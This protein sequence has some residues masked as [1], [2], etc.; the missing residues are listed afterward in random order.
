[1]DVKGIDQSQGLSCVADYWFAMSPW[2]FQT[3]KQN[4]D[5]TDP[6][7]LAIATQFI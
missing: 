2:S 5:Q 6:S 1:M 4:N 7:D 3:S